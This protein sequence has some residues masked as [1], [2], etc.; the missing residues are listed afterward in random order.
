MLWFKR[1]PKN[2]RLGRDFVLDVKLRSSKVRA[3]R[4]RMLAVGLST[5][6]AVV[7]GV[8]LLWCGAE[9]LLT[10]FVYQN[11]AFALEE[12][13][14]Q[15]DG[16]LSRDQIQ[17]WSGV[18]LGE[19]LL[20]LDLVN[21]ERNLKLIPMVQSASIER[22]LPRTLRVR[23]VEREPLAQVNVPRPRP[24]GGIDW[25][26]FH[27]DPDGYVMPPLDN[28]QRDP[29]AP[30]IPEL[31]TE[32]RGLNPNEIQPGRHLDAPQLQAALKLLLAF[33]RSPM[34][35]LVDL[36][37]IDVSASDVLLV[38]TGQGSEVTFSLKDPE[39][40]LARWR[41]IFDPAQKL[42]KAIATLDLAVSNNIPVRLVEVGSVPQ[43]TPK[44]PKTTHP[45]KKH[46]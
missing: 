2:R 15:T 40:Q 20:A 14:I 16:Y 28:S 30:Q 44:P 11:K 26:P 13:D 38:I 23:I 12:I 18:K 9:W 46:V 45:R 6:F 41:T 8:W 10:N 17:R 3:A 37:R 27:L 7:L 34:A 31:L 24:G 19:N 5:C 1:K 39:L 21:L 36:K 43:P 25:A 42:G 35:G 32:I 22:I 4:V 29:S 33:E